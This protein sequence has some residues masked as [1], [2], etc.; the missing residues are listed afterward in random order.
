MVKCKQSRKVLLTELTEL[1]GTCE[2]LATVMEA[3][4]EA[5]NKVE[6]TELFTLRRVQN[7][8]RLGFRGLTLGMRPL[9]QG[10]S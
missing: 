8:L 4:G 9:T 2:V 5:G 1:L 10:C 3:R 7:Q 6:E